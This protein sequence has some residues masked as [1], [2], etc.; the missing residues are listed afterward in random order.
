MLL[1]RRGQPLT[2]HHAS[3]ALVAHGL[4]AIVHCLLETLGR[5][6]DRHAAAAAAAAGRGCL[7]QRS[8]RRQQQDCS[9][10]G[11]GLFIA[12]ARL[13][14]AVGVKRSREGFA[15]S[16]PAAA[17]P[18]AAAADCAAAAGASR[19]QAASLGMSCCLVDAVFRRKA[20]LCRLAGRA[21]ALP[22]HAAVTPAILFARQHGGCEEEV[23]Y[24]A[25]R[26]KE[27]VLGA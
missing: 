3:G 20:P 19:G 11:R 6:A 26:R 25:Y 16:A 12:V 21:A 17:S 8:G 24:S 22:A 7:S 14:V 5:K 15:G 18:A 1:W 13:V 27:C 23:N 2:V 4:V 9:R 10:E